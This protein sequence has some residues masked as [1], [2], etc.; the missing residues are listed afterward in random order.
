MSRSIYQ[1]IL[2]DVTIRRLNANEAIPYSLLLLA[3][4][5]MSAIERYIDL[6]EI[7]IAVLKAKVIASIVLYPLGDEAYEIKNI[8]VAERFQGKG[9]GKLLLNA[10]TNLAILNNA[11]SL[12]IGTSNASVAQLYLYQKSGF[13]IT[14]IK[15]NFFLDN[16]REPIFENGIQCKHMIF[17]EKKLR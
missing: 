8:A 2:K 6:A 1:E 11:G 17:L 12:S 15:F 9:I 13:E 16:Y 4:P 10:A 7:H 5:S 3:D 14:G